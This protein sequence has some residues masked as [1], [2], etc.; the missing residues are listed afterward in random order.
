MMFFKGYFVDVLDIVTQLSDFPAFNA[1][2][3]LYAFLL[4]FLMEEKNVFFF[5]LP[6]K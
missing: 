1:F 5:N 3:A 2:H 6:Y 4:Y